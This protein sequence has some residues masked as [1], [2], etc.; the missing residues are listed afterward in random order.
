MRLVIFI[1]VLKFGLYRGNVRCQLC[2]EELGGLLRQM[3]H[4]LTAAHQ[5]KF[6]LCRIEVLP[7]FYLGLGL[8]SQR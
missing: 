5:L 1:V 4:H 8:S 6:P 7:C 3:E 2:G